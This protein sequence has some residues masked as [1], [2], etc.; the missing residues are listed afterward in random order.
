MSTADTPTIES[1]PPE[2][3][4]RTEIHMCH[5][6]CCCCCCCLHTLGGIIGSA[7]APGYGK[8]NRMPITSYYDEQPDTVDPNAPQT[9]ASAVQV[10][11]ILSLVGAIL[12]A[13]VGAMQGGEGFIIGLVILAMVFPAVQ[14]VMAIIT[15][16][17]LGA[18]SRPDRSFQLGQIGR[19]TLGLVVGTVVGILTM[20]VIGV[21]MSSR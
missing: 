17:W 19:I 6:S 21:V 5:G 3:R 2:R 18:S 12:G 10:Y 11:W 13:W 7:V 8:N 20:V 16:I 14:L 15:A 1:H 4:R 9:G